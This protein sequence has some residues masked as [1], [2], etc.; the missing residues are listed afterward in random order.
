VVRPT[1]NLTVVHVRVHFGKRIHEE[2]IQKIDSMV[3]ILDLLVYLIP[4]AEIQQLFSKSLQLR[5]IL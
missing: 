3:S 2:Y 5:L 1:D 4:Q